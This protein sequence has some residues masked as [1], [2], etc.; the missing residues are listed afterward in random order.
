[1]DA[2]LHA[3]GQILLRAVP[4]FLLVALVHFYLKYIFFKP[5]QKVLDERYEASEGARKLAE[6]SLERADAKAGEYENALRRASAEVY[7]AS[8]KLYKQFQEQQDTELRAARQEAE[9]LVDAAK[10]ELAQDVEAAKVG[11]VRDA[12]LLANQI[13]DTLLSGSA[14]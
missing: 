3:L 2:T 10:A 13:S 14:A 6:Q 5:L 1:M 9:R 7:E 4:T 8:E 12:E 11:L